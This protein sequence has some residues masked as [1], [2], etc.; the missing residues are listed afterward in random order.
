MDQREAIDT[1]VLRPAQ[2][3][4]SPKVNILNVNYLQ[5]LNDL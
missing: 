3:K 1:D 2:I 5:H 4:E